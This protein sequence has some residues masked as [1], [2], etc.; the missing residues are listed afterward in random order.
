MNT[1]TNWLQLTPERIAIALLGAVVVYFGLQLRHS[2]QPTPPAPAA[3]DG[4]NLAAVFA[5][6]PDR[7]EAVAHA[8]AFA[9]ICRTVAEIV[10]KDPKQ[11]IKTGRAL[12]EL[13]TATREFRLVAMTD[14]HLAGQSFA[15]K[16]PSLGPTVGAYLDSTAGK[17]GKEIDLASRA[18]WV[19]AFR[20]LARNSELATQ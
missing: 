9:G 5:V 6:N 20:V 15:A 1:T 10:E 19:K 7:T 18:D 8:K 17:S 12:E 2:N 11:R 4:P 13:R 16:Y 14:A 3:I